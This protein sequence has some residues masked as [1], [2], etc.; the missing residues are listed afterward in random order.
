MSNSININFRSSKDNNEEHVM[1]SRSYNM[2]IMI[3]D[4][5]DEVIVELSESH[6]SNYQI[7]FEIPIKVTDFIFDYIDSLYCKCHKI[8]LKRDGLNIGSPY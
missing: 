8:I 6:F 7:R 2:E 4:K 1:N 5:A 3:N